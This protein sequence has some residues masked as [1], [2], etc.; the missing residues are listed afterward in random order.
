MCIKCF[1]HEYLYIHNGYLIISLFMEQKLVG[2]FRSGSVVKNPSTKQE[3]QIWSLVQEDCLDKGMA[4][5]SSILAREI[6]W[7][8]EPGWLKSMRWKRVRHDLVMKQQQQQV[9]VG[10][11]FN[12]MIL[13]YRFN[14]F[15][16]RTEDVIK[17]I[18]LKSCFPD[19]IA[20]LLSSPLCFWVPLISTSK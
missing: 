7:T 19:I 11:W 2:D 13:L 14:S 4:K 16:W 6:P 1:M 17:M 8:E 18:N 5:H 10:I 12:L 3:T 15:E 9:L 20:H